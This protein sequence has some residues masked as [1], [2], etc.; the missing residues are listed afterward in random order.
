MARPGEAQRAVARL[1]SSSGVL[2]RPSAVRC[3]RKWFTSWEAET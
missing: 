2:G 1:R 3:V